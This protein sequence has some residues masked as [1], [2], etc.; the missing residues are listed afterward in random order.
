ME[1]EILYKRYYPAIRAYTLKNTR[2]EAVAEDITSECFITAWKQFSDFETEEHLKAF[3]YLKSKRDAINWQ[4]SEQRKRAKAADIAYHIATSEEISIDGDEEV[5]ATEVIRLMEFEM[6]KL[7]PTV[8]KVMRMYYEGKNTKE[9]TEIT[10]SVDK[11]VLN[12]K[13][14]AV[15]AIKDAVDRFLKPILLLV[16]KDTSKKAEKD[17]IKAEFIASREFGKG[18]KGKIKR[19]RKNTYKGFL[20]HDACGVYLAQEGIKSSAD[21]RAWKDAGKRPKFVPAQPNRVYV[22]WN[23]WEKFLG[24]PNHWNSV[25][26][27]EAAKT[28]IKVVA[29]PK[30]VT[31]GNAMRKFIH[32]N[33]HLIPKGLPIYPNKVYARMGDW[34]SWEDYLDIEAWSYEKAKKWVHEHLRPLGILTVDKY[35]KASNIIP[36]EMPHSN[37][38]VYYTKYGEWGSE[39]DFFGRDAT[40]KNNYMNIRTK[41]NNL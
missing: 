27:Y 24:V 12:Q 8:S 36:L 7:P 6:K 20:N 38:K 18:K 40:N 17:N 25:M 10:G 5:I 34:V 30:G 32:D 11:T 19:L 29:K 23:G 39:D 13:N 31:S 3:L 1:F 15:H 41:N 28:W 2:D 35:V 4:E 26:S 9:I 22:P 21:F 16:L 37:P 33:P 14:T